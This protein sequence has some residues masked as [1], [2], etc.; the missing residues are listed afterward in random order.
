MLG[1]KYYEVLPRIFVDERDAISAVLDNKTVLDIK[2]YTFPCFFGQIR[3]DITIKPLTTAKRVT[4]A[5]VTMVPDAT[6]SVGQHLQRSQQLIDI[7]KTA[8]A[9]AHG[10][11]SPLNAIKGAVVY[12]SEKY[13][14]E[15]AMTEFVTIMKEEIDRL[16]CFISKFLS[17]SLS[18]GECSLTDINALLKR[19]EIFTSLQAQADEVKTVYEYGKIQPTMINAFQIE[20][21]ILNVINNALEAMHSG[22]Q[23]TV[24]TYQKIFSGSDFLV[25]EIS[26][27]GPG[28][29]K[30]KIDSLA[31][32][33][34]AERGGKGFG[35]FITREI[36]QYYGGHLEIN[37]RKGVGTTI[38]LYLVAKK[39]KGLK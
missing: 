35:L 20:Q 11:R 33:S 7:G 14:Q 28:I 3:A 17:T 31:V 1:R 32:L 22:G 2:S 12:L 39:G 15:A 18:N 10:V 24:R 37:S 36:V 19:I 27:T 8:S 5:K 6:C 21:A 4:A 30:S 34:D 29:A 23:L 9:L 38:R 16:D 13:A 25:I 26:D